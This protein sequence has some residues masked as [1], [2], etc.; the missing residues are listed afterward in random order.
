M[1]KSKMSD[2][3]LYSLVR[4][5]SFDSKSLMIDLSCENRK[6]MR[7]LGRNVEVA[8]SAPEKNHC[9]P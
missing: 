2:I 6:K 7:T 5:D 8:L 1:S 9:W 3:L 4:F